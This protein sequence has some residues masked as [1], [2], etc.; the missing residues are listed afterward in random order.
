[1][2]IG[3]LQEWLSWEGKE[4]ML[5]P[6]NF[7]PRKTSSSRSRFR[8]DRDTFEDMYDEYLGCP[9]MQEHGPELR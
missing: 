6:G 9:Q 3:K 1:M 7:M 2:N 5:G 8:G 4:W